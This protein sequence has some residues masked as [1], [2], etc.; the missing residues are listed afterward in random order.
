M[1]FGPIFLNYIRLLYK[2]TESL[3]KIN[4]SLTA[5][6]PFAKGIRQGC[7]LSG[8]LYTIAIEPFLTQLRR[9]L[10]DKSFRLPGRST[11]C[12]VSA[13]ADD[14]SIFIT[15]ESGFEAIRNT[16]DLF[17]RASAACLNTQKSQGLWAGSW[18]RRSDKPLGFHWNSDGLCF[19]GVHLGSNPFYVNQNWENANIK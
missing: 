14:I 15:Q 8:L 13:Y 16:Y 1:G 5:P 17:S 12:S 4:N 18:T 6:F 19:L 2:G 10:K 7:P 9:N 3:I 11:S